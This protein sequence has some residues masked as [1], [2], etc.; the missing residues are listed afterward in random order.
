MWTDV[1]EVLGRDGVLGPPESVE[2]G[3]HRVGDSD[4]DGDDEV[5][6]GVVELGD[7][8]HGDGRRVLE[9]VL[10]RLGSVTVD[11]AHPGESLASGMRIEGGA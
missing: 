2:D 9:S 10:P 11:H 1:V 6:D 3:S 5:H 7:T 8:L 4:N